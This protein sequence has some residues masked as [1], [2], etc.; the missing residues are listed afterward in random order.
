MGQGIKIW[1]TNWKQQGVQGIQLHRR[2]PGVLPI[3]ALPMTLFS[4]SSQGKERAIRVSIY[5]SGSPSILQLALAQEI[6]V[7]AMAGGAAV[8]WVRA[9]Q[10]WQSAAMNSLSLCRLF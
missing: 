7:E 5:I 3:C 10:H 8:L 6:P 2:M 1:A 9:M 4:S